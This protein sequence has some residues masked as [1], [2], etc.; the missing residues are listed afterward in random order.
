M[1]RRKDGRCGRPLTFWLTPE[2]EDWLRH[3]HPR[4]KMGRALVLELEALR[5]GR[6][7]AP[8]PSLDD[9]DARDGERPSIASPKLCDRCRRIGLACCL[10]CLRITKGA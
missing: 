1:P 9:A 8:E 6:V 5:T 7:K 2:R 10:G 4:R 3:R